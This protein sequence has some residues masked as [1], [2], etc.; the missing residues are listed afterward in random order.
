MLP[1]PQTAPSPL[2]TFDIG[3]QDTAAVRSKAEGDRA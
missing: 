1:V 3:L 2:L